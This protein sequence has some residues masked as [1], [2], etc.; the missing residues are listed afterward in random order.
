MPPSLKTSS[1]ARSATGSVSFGMRIQ[2]GSDV[3]VG[4][5]SLLPALLL[6][7]VSTCAAE[8][9][10]FRSGDELV[11][12]IDD[13]DRLRLQHADLKAQIS[14]AGKKTLA[15]DWSDPA[16]QATLT[17][18]LAGFGP[19]DTISL[20]L[21]NQ[22][23]SARV[24]PVTM[25]DARFSRVAE[26]E[27]GTKW[28]GDPPRVLLPDTSALRVEPLTKPARS[29]ALADIT[30]PVVSETDLPV[31]G[32][33][34]AVL[35]VNGRI[36]FSYRKAVIDE[37]TLRVKHWRK[38]LV[39]VPVDPKWATGTGDAVVTLPASGFR[40]HTS[41]ERSPNG[42]LMLGDTAAGL[43]QGGQ[44]LD[45]DDHGRLYFSN[46][47]HGASLV[48]FDP[49]TGRFEQPP[50]NL[51]QALAKLL[52]ADPAWRRSWDS[53]LMELV[54]M[55]GRVFIVFA[56][57]HRV[58]NANG[59]VEV[60]SGVVSLPLAHWDDAAKFSA[61]LRLHAGCWEGAPNQLYHGEIAAADY[62]SHKLSAPAETQSGL[63]I[64]AAAGSK[65]GP[66]HLEFDAAGNVTRLAEGGTTAALR[67]HSGLKKQRFINIGGAGRP[68]IQFDCGEFRIPRNAVP[69]L[70]PGTEVA[71]SKG[72]FLTK[73]NDTPGTLTVR[74]DV[75]AMA[76][77]GGVVQGPAYALTAIPDEPDQAI[78]VCEYGYYFSRLDFSHLDSDRHVRRTYL[79][80]PGGGA[81]PAQVGLGPYNTLWAQHDDALW[82]YLPG[83][84]G[85]TRLKYAENGRTLAAFDADMFHDRLDGHMIDGA[86]RDSIKDYKELI[87][88]LGG[89]MLNIGRGRPGRGG[90]AF[91][92]GLELFDPRTLGE[93]EVSVWMTRC[94]DIWSPVSRVVL[95][96]Q[97]GSLRQQVFAASSTIRPDYVRDISDRATL[98]ANQEPKVFAWE[99]DADGHLRDLFG[100]ALTATS[101][102]VLSPCG[103]FVLAMQADGVLMTYSIAQRRVVDGAKLAVVPLEFS[104]PGQTIWSAP[105]GQTFIMT[106]AHGISFHEVIVSRDGR[107]SLRPHLVIEGGQ[108]ASFE[109]IVRCFL[110]DLR[111]KDGSYDFVL[112]GRHQGDD[113]SVRVIRDFIL[114]QK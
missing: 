110:P 111:Q 46:V 113:P 89:R 107:L 1:P 32:S 43:G 97:D 68:L 12:R 14:L 41:E 79:P 71:D 54:V 23:L 17:V 104:R 61:D 37:K 13:L 11:I 98:P 90:K 63:A 69:L 50:V 81:M 103:Q 86:H 7:V 60:C 18:D 40:I 26:I 76:A 100:F 28:Q 102:L 2:R 56:R 73:A 96:A 67:L 108:Q 22:T 70:L 30:Y 64:S 25:H 49:S 106:A 77:G 99:C 80:M 87:P 59:N 74:F 83:Y 9:S 3:L 84:I 21:G 29:V 10:A 62:A 38:F 101:Q 6:F 53:A 39:E 44:S 65:G 85:M 48:R 33:Q 114:P 105:N 27:R 91:S 88:A 36:Y 24:A 20:K 93:S 58:K 55:R 19:C 47:E 34:N 15:V 42:F 95:S 57:H 35:L 45:T 31:L 109:R 112:G 92:A 8:I 16:I 52:P 66:W 4:M 78:G 5:K 94:F 51:G 82:L 72:Q 75:R